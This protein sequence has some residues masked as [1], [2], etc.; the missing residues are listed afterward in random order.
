M[1]DNIERSVGRSKRYKLDAGGA[2]SETGPFVGIVKNNT[3]TTRTGKLMVYNEFLSGPDENDSKSWT[4]VSYVSP[5]YGSTEPSAPDSTEG[6]FAQNRHSYGM[7]FTPPDVGTR[8]L[9]VFANGDP[10]IGYYLGSIVNEDAH[11]MM[12][13]IG[14]SSQII[15]QE[16]NSTPY[17]ANSQRLPVVEFNDNNRGLSESQRFFD[18]PKPVHQ[19]QAFVLLQQGLLNDSIR[20]TIGSNSY[21]ESPSTVFG[22]STPG[23]PIY[24][25][26]YNSQNLQTRLAQDANNP[27]SVP[28]ESMRVV[29]REG[30]HS[31]VLDDGDQSGDDQLVR[32]R[33]AKGH[34]ILLSDSGD[35]LYISHANGQSWF[36]LGAEGT[37]DIYAANS[38]N[39]RSGDINFHADRNININGSAI[40]MASKSVFNVEAK[41][42][43][44][45][46]NDSLMMYSDKYVGVK[47]DGTLSL[48][49][50]KT[51]TWEGGTGMTLS[52]GCINLNSG[53]APTVPKTTPI[54]KQKLPDT[55]FEQNVGWTVESNKI[56]S[57]VTR[58]PTHEPWPLHNT[59]VNKVTSYSDASETPLLPEVE[60]KL[61]QTQDAEFT[62]V[63]AEQ[64]ETQE[65][66]DVTIGNLQPEQITGMLAQANLNVNQSFNSIS[67]DLG[68]G[69]FGFSAEQ[70]EGAGYLKAGTT[71]FFLKDGKANLT[72]VLQSSSVWSGKNGVSNLTGVLGDEGLQNFIKTD[73]YTGAFN[74]LRSEGVLTGSETAEN[75]AALVEPASKFGATSVKQWINGAGIDANTTT[76]INK[77]ARSAQYS[78]ELANQK[79]SENIKG[80]NTQNTSSTNTVIRGS[81]DQAATS[82]V[83]ETK[84]TPPSYTRT[85]RAQDLNNPQRLALEQ[86]VNNITSVEIPAAKARY[87]SA[88][89]DKKFADFLKSSEYKS[90]V[91]KRTALQQQIESL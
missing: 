7:W 76:E 31:I 21:R 45:T 29:G 85:A 18:N 34:Q 33:T 91:S 55:K 11:H 64:Y 5:F 16:R 19:V 75:I 38:V 28:V 3:D 79:L 74:D 30:G 17:F 60:E 20:G 6:G 61:N 49:S 80:F 65:T 82:V 10:N 58:A 43:Q 14:S 86:Q 72:T 25:G 13:A 32:I 41:Q 36:E 51:G 68:V 70:L 71:E 90:L 89:P 81:I 48:Q 15:N 46:G 37:V 84:V 87:L 77:I 8:I 66:I 54:P 27:G 42:L 62:P 63:T 24:Q 2:P 23:R 59:G 9:F 78:V 50:S 53:K 12:P 67:S 1:A 57:V 83:T 88:N 69:K 40:N 26:G 44:L 47:S 73:L 56:E 4:P 22:L 35:T 52:A 39:I